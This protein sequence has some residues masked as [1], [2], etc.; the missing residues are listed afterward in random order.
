MTERKLPPVNRPSLGERL[1]VRAVVA[2][3]AVL[4]L[5]IAGAAVLVRG[6][7]APAPTPTP[8]P[9]STAAPMAVASVS[10][11]APPN[12]YVDPVTVT[13]AFFAAFERTRANPKDLSD[14]MQ[15]MLPGSFGAARIGGY[16]DQ[17]YVQ[18]NRAFSASDIT[19]GNCTVADGPLWTRQPGTQTPR[20]DLALK[21]VTCKTSD[22]GQD[23]DLSGNPV[24]THDPVWHDI[25]SA[26][27][28]QFNGLW[29][30]FDWGAKKDA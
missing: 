6:T 23:T 29:Y 5:V 9:S 25:F 11:T 18:K 14:V 12:P 7:Q 20:A 28:Q 8:A 15:Y 3:V 1:P 19:I 17:I 24:G 21:H 22:T 27:V 16:F 30:V 10:P 4:V 13:K 2:I 26:E